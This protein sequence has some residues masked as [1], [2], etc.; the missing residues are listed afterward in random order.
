MR[1]QFFITSL[2]ASASFF[3]LSGY[4]P[5]V[6]EESPYKIKPMLLP[7]SKLFSEVSDK[8]RIDV[9]RWM[10]DL[11]SDFLIN[12]HELSVSGDFSRQMRY[13]SGPSTMINHVK[14]RYGSSNLGKDIRIISIIQS[15]AGNT[16]INSATGY[17]TDHTF[18]VDTLVKGESGWMKHYG[19]PNLQ[20]ERSELAGKWG[21]RPVFHPFRAIVTSVDQI[22]NGKSLDV[23]KHSVLKKTVKRVFKQGDLTFV[24]LEIG[25]PQTSTKR[26]ITFR[27]GCPIQCD[28]WY[29]IDEKTDKIIPYDS[30][31]MRWVKRGESNL[32]V[33]MRGVRRH[34]VRPAEIDFKIKCRPLGTANPELFKVET[35]GEVPFDWDEKDER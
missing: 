24:W 5:L 15:L 23:S 10:S 19:Q 27:D 16:S 1:H 11:E 35:L 20:F 31:Y 34:K 28:N 13:K 6:A 33:V 17:V 8:T 14:F 26:I 32:P 21:F 3:F 7:K 29:K 30:L 25:G 12:D 2:F 22:L 9:G 4:L 18:E